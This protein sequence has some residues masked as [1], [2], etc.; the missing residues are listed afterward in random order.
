MNY[1]PARSN[2]NCDRT[3]FVE[4]IDYLIPLLISRICF[5]INIQ[6]NTG[7]RHGN[8]FNQ[9]HATTVKLGFRFNLH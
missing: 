5:D 1:C 2:N 7:K 9:K 4:V 3:E 8:R 6:S